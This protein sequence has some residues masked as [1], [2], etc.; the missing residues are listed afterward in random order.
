MSRKRN[1]I[2]VFKLPACFLTHFFLDALFL[3]TN[4]QVCLSPN[5]SFQNAVITTID[6]GGSSLILLGAL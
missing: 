1:E 5:Y 6:K 3:Y 2:L 4:T